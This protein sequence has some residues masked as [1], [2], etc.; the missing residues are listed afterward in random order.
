MP[1]MG[2]LFFAAVREVEDSSCVVPDEYGCVD[3]YPCAVILLGGD[4]S[5]R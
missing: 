3:G 4:R 5:I 2:Q 1:V